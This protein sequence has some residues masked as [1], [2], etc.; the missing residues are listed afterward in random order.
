MILADIPN[1]A[2][3]ATE[4]WLWVFAALVILAGAIV[5]CAVGLKQL[6]RGRQPPIEAEFT[7]R[8]EF[9]EHVRDCSAKREDLKDELKRDSEKLDVKISSISQDLWRT[10][11]EDRNQIDA[12]NEARTAKILTRL[13]EIEGQIGE[14]RGYVQ[15]T[16]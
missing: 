4:T 8:Q 15:R 1:P 7:S 10:I 12:A 13:G 2:P 11:R 3:G 6:L 5:G 14:L 9:M 16:S